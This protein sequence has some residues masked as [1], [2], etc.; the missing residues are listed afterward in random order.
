MISN[1]EDELNNIKKKIVKTQIIGAP[2]AI[3]LGLGLYGL[4]GANGDAFHPLLN[5]ISIVNSLLIV[6][7]AIELWQLYVLI[8]LFKKQSKLSRLI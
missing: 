2:G 3:L 7:V 8:P 1:N 6:G 5:Y 4:F